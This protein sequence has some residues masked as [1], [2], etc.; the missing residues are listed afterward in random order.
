MKFGD[1]HSARPSIMSLAICLIMLSMASK[2][3][4][5]K[6]VVLVREVKVEVDT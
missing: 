5:R 4:G 1:L 2:V 3:S 6:I